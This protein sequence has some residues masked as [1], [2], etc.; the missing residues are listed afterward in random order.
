MNNILEKDNELLLSLSQKLISHNI[1]LD[2]Q[3]RIID[4]LGRYK[5]KELQDTL[6]EFLSPKDIQVISNFHDNMEAFSN[7]VTEYEMGGKEDSKVLRTFFFSGKRVNDGLLTPA[8]RH[9]LNFVQNEASLKVKTE[10]F[11]DIHSYFKYGCFEEDLLKDNELKDL[12]SS[13]ISVK[14]NKKKGVDLLGLSNVNDAFTKTNEGSLALSGFCTK[15]KELNERRNIGVKVITNKNNNYLSINVN[16]DYLNKT[17]IAKS[18]YIDRV[19]KTPQGIVVSLGTSD[20]SF[21]FQSER[22][23]LAKHIA[24]LE[25]A[26]VRGEFE[27]YA[28]KDIHAIDFYGL[29]QYTRKNGEFLQERMISLGI[30][31]ELMSFISK[32]LGYVIESDQISEEMKSKISFQGILCSDLEHSAISHL[33]KTLNTLLDKVILNKE[34]IFMFCNVHINLYL[35]TKL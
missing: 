34:N 27:N 15:I 22:E 13:V 6:S 21:E 18:G 26:I 12:H 10:I 20:S 9:V 8:Y 5:S 19:K 30:E 31:P 29:T 7:L 24:A 32:S 28:V 2:E 23:Q 16:Y 35:K 11:F 25:V 33:E 14:R 1:D 3:E 4:L 17:G